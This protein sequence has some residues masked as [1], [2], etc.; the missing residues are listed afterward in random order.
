MEAVLLGVILLLIGLRTFGTGGD[1]RESVTDTELQAAG[2]EEAGNETVAVPESTG[3]VDSGK[4]VKL[5]SHVD[6]SDVLKDITV[7][8]GLRSPTAAP[9]QETEEGGETVTE[10]AASGENGNGGE[11]PETEVTL[12]PSL[13]VT[14][15]PEAANTPEATKTPEPTKTPTP[16]PTKKPTVSPTPVPTKKATLSPTPV[17]TKK[18]T[19]TPTPTRKPTATPTPTGTLVRRTDIEVLLMKEINDYREAHGI[20]VWEAPENFTTMVTVQSTNE[21]MTLKEWMDYRCIPVAKANAVD[22]SADHE[23]GQMGAAAQLIGSVSAQGVADKFF[24][25]WMNSSL[26]CS[27]MLSDWRFPNDDGTYL[28]PMH[29]NVAAVYV[30]Q[31]SYGY[32]YDNFVAVWLDTAVA[33]YDR[34]SG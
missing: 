20:P 1:G 8:D 19:V 33:E 24:Q 18:T 31:Y 2:N 34:I 7:A 12:S 10:E 27:Q 13:T 16:V 14:G 21:T 23:A 25:M 17:P 11:I 15:A 4:S 32:Y 6:S 3:T 9:G 30:Y 22:F 29:V 5:R 26:H 28:I